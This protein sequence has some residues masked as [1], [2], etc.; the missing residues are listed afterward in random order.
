MAA[1]SMRDTYA[2]QL[3]SLD[4]RAA[5]CDRRPLRG[6]PGR[7]SRRRSARTP[8]GRVYVASQRVRLPHRPHAGRRVRHASV[9]SGS[10]RGFDRSR[11]DAERLQA[12]DRRPH[13]RGHRGRRRTAIVSVDAAVRKG[14]KGRCSST[15]PRQAVP[16]EAGSDEQLSFG[17]ERRQ[18]R[19][20]RRADPSRAPRRGALHRLGH[21]RRG[22]P[23]RGRGGERPP[24]APEADPARGRRSV[25]TLAPP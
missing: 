10:L 8:A 5:R 19:R 15:L 24:A 4:S 18:A 16:I 20:L 13:G 9:S 6:H 7:R 14:K 2:G 11:A 17:L 22:Q 3:R 21:R 1:T 12:D 23:R 25:P